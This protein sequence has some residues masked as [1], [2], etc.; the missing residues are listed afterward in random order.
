VAAVTVTAETVVAI[1]S[2]ILK[3]DAL[4]ID[5]LAANQFLPAGAPRLS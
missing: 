2:S 3:A 1:A 4:A 5:T